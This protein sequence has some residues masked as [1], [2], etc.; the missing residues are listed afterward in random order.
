MS[1]F[2]AT[3]T[4][5]E[6]QEVLGSGQLPLNA[7]PIGGLS[8]RAAPGAG[9][10]KITIASLSVYL[11]T[12]PNFPNSN[13]GLPLMSSTFANNV[14]PDKTL[15]FSGSNITLSD[16]G[17]AKP[18]PCPFDMTIVFTTPFHYNGSELTAGGSILIDMQATNFSATSGAFDQA[19]FTAPGGSVAQVVGTLGSATGT[20]AY[21]SSIV[22]LTYTPPANTPSITG[23]VNV[24]SNIPPGVPNYALAQ[25]ALFAVYGNNMGPA[26]LSVASLPLPT[27]AGLSGTSI[28]VNVGGT[29]VN[30]PIYFTRTDVVVGVMPS[31]TPTGNGILTVLYKGLRFAAS[32]TVT[33]SAFGISNNLNQFTNNGIGVTSNAAVTF[34]NFQ[35]VG[36]NYTAKPGDALTVWGTGLGAT[37]NNGSDTD[38]PPFG[39]IG[40]APQVYIGGVLS[41][42][43]T[44]WGRAPGSIPGLD[45][46]NFVVPMDAP[47]GCNVSIVV[48]TMNGTTPIVSNGPDIALAA[49]DGATCSDPTEY[50]PPS[51]LSA[52]STK[53]L[54]LGVSQSVNTNPNANGTTTSTTHSDAQAF[55]FSATQAQLQA[56]AQ[57]VNVEPSF[58]TCYTGINANPSANGPGPNV[59]PL[60]AGNT[61]TLTPPSGPAIMLASQSGEYQ[62]LSGSAAYP[63]GTW[64]FSNGA[65]GADVGP[66][67]FTFPIPQQ[68]TWTNMSALLT[69]PITRANGLTIT[70]TGGDA[71]GY[72]DIQGYAGETAAG[73]YY[74]GF[75]CA[76]PA[77]A[78]TFTVPPSILLAMPTNA[79]FTSLQVSTYAMPYSIGNVAGFNAAINGSQ[80]QTNIPVIFK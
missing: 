64:G 17:C 28:T 54:F 67:S 72:V 76:A 74:V 6:I 20:F 13:N 68:V 65:G 66:L 51:A 11:S 75:E 33:Q 63:S 21:Q 7:G 22:Q 32:V 42:S 73:G 15:V 27:T 57:S 53:V 30:A 59:T 1:S 12:S 10:T 48:E 25:G 23:V 24:A 45:Q 3:A 52:A 2:P 5:L 58:G 19:S 62:S 31:N 79:V 26:T 80:F 61:L 44:Y 4:S 9:P 69:S 71:N 39:N 56:L 36:Q 43:V 35:A 55:I 46:I 38:A 37:P 40:A 34:A 50:I 49:T 70:W 77:T 41:P 78:G 29:V 60:D 8:F 47:L 14:G 18:G 16:A